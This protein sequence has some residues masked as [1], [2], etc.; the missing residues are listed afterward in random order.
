MEEIDNKKSKTAKFTFKV[1]K[2]G[3]N[4]YLNAYVSGYKTPK[5]KRRVDRIRVAS[6]N[7]KEIAILE[8]RFRKNL[9][10]HS[11]T[12]AQIYNETKPE[13][14][15]IFIWRLGSKPE[16]VNPA[17][18]TENVQHVISAR[19]KINGKY[20]E[21]RFSARSKKINHGGTRDE[22]IRHLRG[23]IFKEGLA[24]Y[25][26]KVELSNIKHSYEHYS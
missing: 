11:G 19:V 22:A 26:D 6:G 10:F 2:K 16:Y 23:Q 24:V 14:N 17:G 9:S 18:T 5:D 13:T 12:T 20:I 8:H 25:T 1:T 3:N 21:K 7:K 4:K 15:S